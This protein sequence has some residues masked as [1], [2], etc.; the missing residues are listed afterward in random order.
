MANRGE[1]QNCDHSA[2][3]PAHRDSTTAGTCG[4]S[5]WDSCKGDAGIQG[6]L[7]EVCQK[8]SCQTDPASPAMQMEYQENTSLVRVSTCNPVCGSDHGPGTS[9]FGS[10][11]WSEAGPD[12][13]AIHPGPSSC[14][15]QQCC[16]VPAGLALSLCLCQG[17][18]GSGA[19]VAMSTAG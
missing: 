1:L 11:S 9:R 13:G 3:Q 10:S 6:S 15:A 17:T 2:A 18:E 14:S 12:L 7:E 8:T 16:N 19:D 5:R 4:K